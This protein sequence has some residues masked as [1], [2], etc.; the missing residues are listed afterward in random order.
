MSATTRTSAGEGTKFI[1]TA[2]QEELRAT[3][4]RY[5]E[6]RFDRD[7]RRRVIEAPDGPEIA[8]WQAFARELDVP[9]ILVPEELGGGGGGA[10]ELAVIAEELGRALYASPWFASC[11]LAIPAL[12]AGAGKEGTELVS[13]LSRAQTS[14]TVVADQLVTPTAHN[15]VTATESG[16]VS[17]LDGVARFVV[18]GASAEHLLVLAA[19]DA[20]GS[21]YLVGPER[22]G[23]SVEPLTTLDL[24]RRV[25]AV[26]FG[27]APAMRLG[28]AGTS[29]AVLQAV[30]LTA[31]LASSAESVGGMQ[32]C[33][34]QATEYAKT[35]YQFGRP[36]GSFQAVKHKLANML[37][38]VELARTAVQHAAWSVATD[39]PEAVL[40]V[41]MAKA[42]VGDAYVAVTGENI[43]A[44]GGIGFTYDHDAHLYFRRSK[45]AQLMFGDPG[46]HRD[47]VAEL[48]GI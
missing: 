39:D 5:M 47:R 46:H 14:A 30:G 12:F 29:P 40:A 24:T 4:R 34:E 37:V 42:Q 15:E 18:D 36:I 3:L 45:A 2:E 48:V 33:L 27:A 20:G 22:T 21:L 44:H 35:R 38:N 10:L 16:G 31:C 28:P 7:E 19:D 32:F 8:S 11:V 41:H 9:A 17:V 23:V 26:T 43:Q 1:L 25:A 13:R 6:Q